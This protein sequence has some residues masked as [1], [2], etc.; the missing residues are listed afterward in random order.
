VDGE[1]E[2]ISIITESKMH[3]G[4]LRRQWWAERSIRIT[5]LACIVCVLVTHRRARTTARWHVSHV[6]EGCELFRACK[7][8]LIMPLVLRSFKPGTYKTRSFVELTP[9][10]QTCGTQSRKF[11]TPSPTSNDWDP[12]AAYRLLRLS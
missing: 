6:W 1:N 9:K 8:V 4:T 5:M 3:K 12:R 10:F 7:P 2:W 11:R